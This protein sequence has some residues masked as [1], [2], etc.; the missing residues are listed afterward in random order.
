MLSLFN[1]SQLV[2][3]NVVKKMNN[4]KLNQSAI[5]NLTMTPSYNAVASLKTLK[6]R[7][8]SIGSIKKIT[9]AM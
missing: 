8:K 7:M 3:N 9:K 4:D 5:K 1:K 6:L 2:F